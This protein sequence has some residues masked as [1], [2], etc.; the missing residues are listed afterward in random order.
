MP[1]SGR[2]RDGLR[3]KYD[4]KFVVLNL[5]AGGVSV[6]L[7]RVR[8]GQDRPSYAGLAPY[9]PGFTSPAN[10]SI[11]DMNSDSSRARGSRTR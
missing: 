9:T 1:L 11:W 2:R 5:S 10:L 8:V 4:W 6:N 7:T 3:C